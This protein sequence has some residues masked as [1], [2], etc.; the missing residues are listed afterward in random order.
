MSTSTPANSPNRR[1]RHSTRT[2]ERLFRAAL[3]L[4]AKKGFSETTVEDIT[5]AADLGK[6][7]FFNYFPSKEH[8]LLAFAEMQFA[9]LKS[10]VEELRTSG[11]SMSQFL[12]TLAVRMTEEP[13][14]NPSIVRALLLANLSTGAVRDLMR[15]NQTRA[16][17][18]I[19][20]FVQIGQERG[21]LRKDLSSAEIAQVFRQTVFGTLLIWSLSGDD[22]LTARVHCALDVLWGGLAPRVPMISQHQLE[23]RTAGDLP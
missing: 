11:E 2:R 15:A 23:I 19:A 14:R 9:K 16:H 3:D 22:S 5:N 21:E 8:L 17:A 6:G 12:R 13:G 4:F 18:L 1:Q 20:E 10:T 7:T